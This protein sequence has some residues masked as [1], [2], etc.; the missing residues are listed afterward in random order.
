MRS[1]H[2]DPRRSARHRPPSPRP[3]TKRHP[4]ATAL[5]QRPGD[6]PALPQPAS[7]PDAAPTREASDPPPGTRGRLTETLALATV[8]VVVL[9][10]LAAVLTAIRGTTP[11]L[12]LGEANRE[13]VSRTLSTAARLLIVVAIFVAGVL[14]STADA[15]R[16]SGSRR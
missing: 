15:K 13:F 7:A 9:L 4:R 16:E 5:E 12:E 14:V 3:A 2:A 10:A 11:G 6:L 1:P 8:A